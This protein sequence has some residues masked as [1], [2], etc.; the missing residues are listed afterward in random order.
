MADKLGMNQQG[1]KVLAKLT[2]SGR[3]IDA[4]A[5]PARGVIIF[6]VPCIDL[7][8]IDLTCMQLLVRPIDM[9]IIL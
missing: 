1:R 5:M 8:L 7:L 4:H 3:P 9:V 6:F 2:C